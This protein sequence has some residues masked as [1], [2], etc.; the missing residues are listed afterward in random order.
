MPGT[1]AQRREKGH[2]YDSMTRSEEA[3]PTTVQR[4]YP[5][6]M[7]GPSAP[8]ERMRSP[9][10]ELFEGPLE[11][12]HEWHGMVPQQIGQ[13][14]GGSIAGRKIPGNMTLRQHMMLR[15]TEDE[16]RCGAVHTIKCKFC[17]EVTLRSW[18]CYQRHCNESEDHPAELT[19]CD[20]CGDYFARPDSMKRHIGR[21]NCLRTSPDNTERKKKT[22]KWGFDDFNA[23][24]EHCLRTREELGRPF[25]EIARENDLSASK[26]APK[27]NKTGSR[28]DSQ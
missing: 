13:K 17:P 7:L 11:T 1:R 24:L 19:Y 9:V 28:G 21:K 14:P 12:Q 27:D 10:Q 6:P 23:R 26:K 16:A 2:I 4:L 8:Q 22:T 5:H 20:Q 15:I 18:Q 25:A 3:R